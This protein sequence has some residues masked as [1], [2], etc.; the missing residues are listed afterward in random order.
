MTLNEK[1][2]LAWRRD[3]HR[4]GRRASGPIPA[5]YPAH[6]GAGRIRPSY[7]E[8]CLL[9]RRRLGIRACINVPIANHVTI[10]RIEKDAIR[11]RRGY[12][13]WLC[14]KADAMCIGWEDLIS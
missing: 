12:W 5:Q 9:L 7:G 4:C 1:R 10:L 3:R 8:R 11:D 13:K 6:R 2:F 14:Q